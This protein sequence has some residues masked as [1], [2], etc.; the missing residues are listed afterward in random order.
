MGLDDD[1]AYN[2]LLSF[3]T[4][5]DTITKN[6]SFFLP[7]FEELD[8]TIFQKLSALHIYPLGVSF[9]PKLHHDGTTFTPFSFLIHDILH[10]EVGLRNRSG[11][12]DD[13]CSLYKEISEKIARL[14]TSNPSLVTNIDILL[15]QLTH[16]E[17]KSICGLSEKDVSGMP[18][19]VQIKIIEHKHANKAFPVSSE[20]VTEASLE[21]A[22][23][24][25]KPLLTGCQ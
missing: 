4:F 17:G 5:R 9:E 21:Q 8:L 19:V 13:N 23:N 20:L 18:L 16:E 24:W 10:T 2:S 12:I 15:F 1:A 22:A 14:K 6:N 7:V 25:L 3:S 11:T